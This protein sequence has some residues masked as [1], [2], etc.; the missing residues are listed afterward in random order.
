MSKSTSRKLILLLLILILSG[1]AVGC[2]SGESIKIR[3]P[4]AN[5]S[6]PASVKANLDAW[7]MG[8]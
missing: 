3:L 7:L 1:T 8:R 2:L 5:S 4:G 6:D